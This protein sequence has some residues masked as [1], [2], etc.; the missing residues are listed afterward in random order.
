MAAPQWNTPESESYM[1]SL[2][3]I[4]EI[5]KVYFYSVGLLPEYIRHL[6]GLTT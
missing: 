3:L 5:R 2:G 6:S 4:S 1:R